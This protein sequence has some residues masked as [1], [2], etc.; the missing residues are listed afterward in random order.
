MS[1]F[2]SLFIVALM[3]SAAVANGV[4]FAHNVFTEGSVWDAVWHQVMIV[5]AIGLMI[6][7]WIR[8]IAPRM[9]GTR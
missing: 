3:A 6:D 4:Q 1:Y 7:E 5:I 2:W 9:R 8:G